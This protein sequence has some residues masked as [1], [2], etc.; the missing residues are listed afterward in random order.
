MTLLGFE[1]KLSGTRVAEL[2]ELLR[3]AALVVTRRTRG[4]RPA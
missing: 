2:G 1:G 4:R 3:D